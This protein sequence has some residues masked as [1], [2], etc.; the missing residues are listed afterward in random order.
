MAKKTAPATVISVK[1]F[2]HELKCRGFAFEVGKTYSVTGA[3]KACENGFHACENP[4][5]CLELLSDR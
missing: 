5:R 3:I 2:D 4:F 1:G